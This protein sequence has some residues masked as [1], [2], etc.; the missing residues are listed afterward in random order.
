[1]VTL[2]VFS[3][4]TVTKKV[5]DCADEEGRVASMAWAKQKLVQV[6]DWVS[7]TS[8]MDEKLIGYVE[9]INGNGRVMVHVTQSDHDEAVGEWVES[10]LAKL[11]KLDDYLPHDVNDL[12]SLM[13]I[14]LM[15][16]DE[17]WFQEL[18]AALRIAQDKEGRG[19]GG[20]GKFYG[21]GT[22][23]GS[24]TRRVKID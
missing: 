17:A 5:S 19:T 7:G 1:M 10:T 3:R 23:N 21:N 18:G 2:S 22:D 20:K 16:R 12:Q 9:S 14:A 11:E 4:V 13:D 24:W 8:L 6:G 15:A